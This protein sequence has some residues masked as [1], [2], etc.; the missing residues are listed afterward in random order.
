MKIGAALRLKLLILLTA[1]SLLAP[2]TVLAVQPVY[3]IDSGN[4]GSDKDLAAREEALK[5]S[6]QRLLALKKDVDQRITKYQDLLAQVQDALKLLKSASGKN[7]A[8]LVKVYEIMPP[9]NTAQALSKLDE[10]TA[11]KIMLMMKPRKAAAV[12]AQMPPQVASA[13]SNGMLG[14]GKKIPIR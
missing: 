2:A 10:A 7:T 5:V 3:K 13:I 1:F 8:Q 9:E 6:E 11:V 12:M 4:C 14:M